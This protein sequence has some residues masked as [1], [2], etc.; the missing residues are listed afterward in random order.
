M[1]AE[2]SLLLFLVEAPLTDRL[3]MVDIGESL[4]AARDAADLV[5]I[6]YEELPVAADTAGADGKGERR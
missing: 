4:D 2:D 6:D 1:S 5:V 3:E